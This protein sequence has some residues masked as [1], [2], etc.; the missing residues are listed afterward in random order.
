M[1]KHTCIGLWWLAMPAKNLRMYLREG[2]E[3]NSF[4]SSVSVCIN[5]D[6]TLGARVWNK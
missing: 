2:F 5:I 3:M 1:I 6:F 4:H